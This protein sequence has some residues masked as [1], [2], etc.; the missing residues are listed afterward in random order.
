MYYITKNKSSGYISDIDKEF[1]DTLWG[2]F[3]DI[4]KPVFDYCSCKL[5]H[6]TDSSTLPRAVVI[7]TPLGETNLTCLSTGAKALLLA[8]SYHRQGKPFSCDIAIF[9][10]NF[11]KF[12]Q[13]HKELFGDITFYNKSRVI[14]RNSYEWKEGED[15]EYIM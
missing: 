1:D 5:V 15:Y 6:V 3:K 13:L 14:L 8:A 7:R 11:L 2:L 4:Y 12:L 10:T 9:G